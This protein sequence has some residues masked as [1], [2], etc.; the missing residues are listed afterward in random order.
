MT[1]GTH[2]SGQAMIE[3][4][5][6]GLLLLVPLMWTLGVLADIHRT[7]LAA[8]AAVREAGFEAARSTGGAHA[9]RA[10]DRAVA[11]AFANQG[12]DPS[13]ARVRVVTGGLARGAPVEIEISYPVTVVQAP[14]LGRVSG[15]SIWIRARHVAR[16]DPYRSRP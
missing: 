2:Q 6:L 10:V 14:L 8:T 11:H 12:L 4:I 3:T 15:P 1:T 16:V 13:A 9:A 7:A 5:L